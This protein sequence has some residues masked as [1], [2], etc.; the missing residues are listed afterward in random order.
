MSEHKSK[1]HHINKRITVILKWKAREKPSA[2]I[3][4]NLEESY[5]HWKRDSYSTEVPT[6]IQHEYDL[7]DSRD[8]ETHKSLLRAIK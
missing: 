8:L 4:S 1:N 3:K 7:A 5:L 6:N 2:G